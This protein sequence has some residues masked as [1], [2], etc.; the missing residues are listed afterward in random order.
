MIDPRETI[1]FQVRSLYLKLDRYVKNEYPIFHEGK[2]PVSKTQGMAIGFFYRNQ[3]KE[4]FQKDLEE[5][6]SI[7]KSTASGLVSRMVKNGLVERTPSVHD[8][9]YKRI[10]LTK[11]TMSEMNK[12]DSAADHLEN[13]LKKDISSEDLKVFFKVLEKI[14]DNAE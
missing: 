7:S 12:I 14:Y 5:A 11:E 13:S 8:A 1:I 4:V 10:R 3:D 6:M 9:R 2:G